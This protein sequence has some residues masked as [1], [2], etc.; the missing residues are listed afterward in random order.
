MFL[1]KSKPQETIRFH[2]DR[3]LDN[4]QLLRDSYGDRFIHMDERMWQLLKWAVEYH[5]VG[6]A[7][8]NF[9]NRLRES[10]DLPLLPQTHNYQVPHNFLSVVLIPL[11]QLGLN[12]EECR[13]LVQAIGYH[14]EREVIIK[15]DLRNKV[16]EIIL[17]DILLKIDDL[18]EHMK[19]PLINKPA[20]SSFDWLKKRYRW[21]TT[22]E[23]RAVFLKYVMLKGLLHRL[24]H[25]ASAHIDIEQGVAQNIGEYVIS[26]F[27]KKKFKKRDLQLFAEVNKDKHLIVIAQTGM[28]K[29]E[30]GLLWIDKAKA[31]F[32]LP[33]RVSINAMYDRVRDPNGINFSAEEGAVGL[34]HSS[35]LDYLEQENEEIDWEI[36]NEHSRQLA[37][38]LLITTIDQILKFPFYYLGF[39]KEYS[40]LAGAK[41]VIDEMQSYDPKIA[42]LIIRALEMIDAIGGQFMVMTATMPKLYLDYILQKTEI[43]L[44]E[45]KLKTF[46]DDSLKRHRLKLINCGIEDYVDE[47]IR[48]GGKKKVLVICNTVKKAVTLYEI[49]RNR[50]VSVQVLHSLFIQKDRFYLEKQIKRFAQADLNGIWITTQLVEASIDI[51][52]DVLF[53]EMSVLD[54]LF[55]RLGRCYRQRKLDNAQPNIWVFTKD[56]SGVPYVYD[57][58]LV[59]KSIALLQPYD[60]KV[61]LESEKMKLIEHLYEPKNLHGTQFLEVFEKTLAYLQTL[62]PYDMDKNQAQKYLRDIHHIRVIPRNIFDS[63]EPLLGE[64]QKEEDKAKRRRLRRKINQYTLSINKYRA[65]K[66]VS[67]NELPKSL[68]NI[69]IINLE[70]EFDG[71]SGKGL[72]L[73]ES[74]SLFS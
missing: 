27:Q 39:E 11:Y 71:N 41:I 38:K 31:F 5:D 51:D 61:I 46:I 21:G 15:Q 54:S 37:N 50:N 57:K 30:A 7:D 49:L 13:L 43:K 35:S 67:Y 29:T 12:E 10:L 24:D 16:K 60:E 42:A 72:I 74:L 20:F 56:M 3:L 65:G 63:I 28:G 33:L 47:M 14:H 36:Y 55:Q 68:R 48:L 69:A 32:T 53:T 62:D 58:D 64:Y 1:A 22:E 18:I 66:L 6:K 34:L 73:N 8:T 70:Y 2:T 59:E 52:F 26:Y 40:V 17:E 25:A 45:I 4:Y 9:Q 19:I 23:E 44:R